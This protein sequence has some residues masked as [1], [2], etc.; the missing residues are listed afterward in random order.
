[1]P[2]K[3]SQNLAKK[4]MSIAWHHVTAP[5]QEELAKII[6]EHNKDLIDAAGW[7]E[8]IGHTDWCECCHC[9]LTAILNHY[10][11]P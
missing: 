5:G 7:F 1:M 8:Q 10:R 6:D 2:S 3:S 9:Q 11:L 4:I